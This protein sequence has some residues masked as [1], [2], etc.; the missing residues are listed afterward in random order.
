ME[1][2]SREYYYLV[3]KFEKEFKSIDF[4]KEE[5]VLHCPR[6]TYQNR[7]IDNLFDAYLKGYVQG[8]IIGAEYGN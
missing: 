5:K 2:N 3:D 7:V 6:V 1:L 4:D 8:K